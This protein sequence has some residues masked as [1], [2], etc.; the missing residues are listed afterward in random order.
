MS[1]R[2]K[3]VNILL[4]LFAKMFIFKIAHF[5]PLDLVMHSHV[6][7]T[8]AAFGVCLG[9][10]PA[11]STIVREWPEALGEIATSSEFSDRRLNISCLE[12]TRRNAVTGSSRCGAVV[13]KS[14]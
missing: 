2:I 6:P 12:L 3:F 5:V 11:S 1:I 10:H 13:N 7:G 9:R 14:N 4:R 8:S